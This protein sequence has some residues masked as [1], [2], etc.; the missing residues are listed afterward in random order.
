ML[1]FTWVLVFLTISGVISETPQDNRDVDIVEHPYIV[2]IQY[3]NKHKCGG[4][5]L[6]EYNIITSAQC[7][8][9]YEHAWNVMN[10]IAIVTGTH[11]LKSSGHRFH[12][13]ETFSQ[14]YTPTAI[15]MIK[16][17]M[18]IK[19]GTTMRSINLSSTK[20]PPG[21]T[22]Q[23]VGWIES[24]GEHNLKK[25]TLRAIECQS[26]HEEHFSDHEFCTVSESDDICKS[27]SGSALIYEG[28]LAG[29]S[30]RVPCKEL[31]KLNV[32]RDLSQ[33]QEYITKILHT[34]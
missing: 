27:D 16:L 30:T 31:R 29:L 4:V 1:Q 13:K 6:D 21:A 5:I 24:E 23:M 8:P 18:P 15:G 9:R 25:V 28:K 33:E 19:F 14:N 12:V 2:S 10:I 22:L 3:S 26:T 11:T 32:H 20:V 17:S 7:V 34:S